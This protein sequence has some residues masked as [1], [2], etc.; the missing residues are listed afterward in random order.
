MGQLA[1]F[2]KL[3]YQLQGDE[4]PKKWILWKKDFY[5]KIVTKNSNWDS[6]FL[7]LIDL[8][9]KSVSMVIHDVFQKLNISEMIM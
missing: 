2:E 9:N 6:I 8:T 4:V 5:K 3:L 7:V 1:G